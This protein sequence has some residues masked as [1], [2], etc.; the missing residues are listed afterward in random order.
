M[1]NFKKTVYV[2]IVSDEGW[3]CMRM[4][5]GKKKDIDNLINEYKKNYRVEMIDRKRMVVWA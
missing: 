5:K 3:T 4:L 2:T 1:F